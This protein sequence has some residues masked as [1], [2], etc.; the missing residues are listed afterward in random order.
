[1]VRTTEPASPSID[2]WTAMAVGKTGSLFG[3]ATALGGIAGGAD[4]AAVD[5]LDDA[6][7]CLGAAFQIVDDVLRVCGDEEDL[8]K[9]VVSRPA[10]NLF[11][12]LAIWLAHADVRGADGRPD[13]RAAL[14]LTRPAV[15][16]L[17]ARALSLFADVAVDH[18]AMTGVTEV[19]AASAFRSH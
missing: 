9:P 10:A 11:P 7:R 8:G 15:E 13:L 6:G 12:P 14:A 3:C 4:A 16:H 5:T 18:D 17:V 1:M 2:R 19:V